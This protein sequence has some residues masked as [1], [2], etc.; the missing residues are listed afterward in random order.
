MFTPQYTVIPA[1]VLIQFKIITNSIVYKIFIA[2]TL[3]YFFSQLI[4]NVQADIIIVANPGF[5]ADTISINKL[6]KLW[7]GKTKKISSIG[8]VHIIDQAEYNDSTRLFYQKIIKKKPKQVKAYWAKLQFIGKGFPPRILQNDNAVIKW[9][10]KT[11][12]G[13]GYIDSKTKTSNL[14]ILMTISGSAP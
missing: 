6:K 13:I 7:L 9:L 1:R 12:N 8:R 3:M 14:K 2:V 10:L 4:D 11:K 5:K